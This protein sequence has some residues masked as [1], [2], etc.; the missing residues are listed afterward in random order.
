M[1]TQ[2]HTEFQTWLTDFILGLGMVY[3][4]PWFLHDCGCNCCM[5]E[6]YRES[7]NAAMSNF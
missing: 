6:S 5:C 3:T 4:E 1:N 7:F 2:T